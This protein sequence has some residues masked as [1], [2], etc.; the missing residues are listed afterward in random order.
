M[1]KNDEE[2][3]SGYHWLLFAICFLGT[4][5]A[6]TVSTLMSVY[7]PVAVRDFL[8]DQNPDELNNIS[9]Y[10]NA[11]F[12]FGGAI[13][14]FIS[15]WISDR[16]GRKTGVILSIAS[17]GLFTILT[18]YMPSWWAVVICRFFTGFGLGGVLVTTTTIMMEEWPAK[19]RAI[20]IG[21]LSIGIPVGI[22][23]AGLMN[24]F[25]S[26]WRQ[27]FLVGAI[28]L[29]ISLISVWVLRESQKWLSERHAIVQRRKERPDIFAGRYRADL[30]TGSTIFGTMLIGMWAIFSWIPTWI[31]S[32][33]TIGDAQKE[34]GL[35]MMM[36]GIGGLTG[37]FLSGWLTNAIGLRRSMLLCFGICI[38]LSFIMFKTN[39]SFSALIYAE[40]LVMALF[41]GASQG[42]LS[43]Y[44]PGLFPV[45]IRGTATGFCFNTGR[46]FTA[47]AV[48]FV[49]VL[50]TRLG[51][52]GNSLFIFSLVF[53]IGLVVTYFTRDKADQSLALPESGHLL[54]SDQ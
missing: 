4:V 33:I 11:V 40:I 37:G 22:F 28:P 32:L 12:I 38:L 9:A 47:T 50:V 45:G 10:I 46:L 39:A 5:F 29:G 30:L 23:S 43:V 36:L 34:R 26:S 52:Y 42:V 17:Y 13:G 7:L 51:G 25:V 53:V 15:G 31:Q 20:F 21:I 27:G 49:G 54:K 6:G 3:L 48:L 14:G 24:Y 44:V 35:S 19:S 2:S 41:F 1:T 18:G 16:Y 8:G